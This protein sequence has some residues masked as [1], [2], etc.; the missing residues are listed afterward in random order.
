LENGT[1]PITFQAVVLADWLAILILLSTIVGIFGASYLAVWFENRHRKRNACNSLIR[2]LED[3]E[4]ELKSPHNAIQ[5]KVEGVYYK[6][7]FFNK[8]AL[9]VHKSPNL[10]LC[11]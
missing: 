7:A 8:E 6:N 11:Y 3:T 5:R 2:E 9:L 4:A 1:Q 10:S